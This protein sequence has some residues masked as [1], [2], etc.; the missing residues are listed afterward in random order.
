MKRNRRKEYYV[1]EPICYSTKDKTLLL[2]FEPGDTITVD[3]LV[4]PDSEISKYRWIYAQLDKEHLTPLS[5]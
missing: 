4:G 3:D 5:I 1:T 2:T